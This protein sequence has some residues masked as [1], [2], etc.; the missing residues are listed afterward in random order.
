[1]KRYKHAKS[2]EKTGFYV[3]L[4]IC[5]VAVGLAVWSAYTGISDYLDASDDGY[6]ASLSD[7]TAAAVAQDMTGVTEPDT[8]PETEEPTE[9]PTEEATT[10]RSFTLYETST[11]PRS[12]E[13]AVLDELDSLSAVLRVSHSLIYP[14]K[15]QSV[16]KQ[17]S[18]DA[19]YSKTMRDYRAHTGCD[20]VAE[21]G[22][23]V[24]A[25]CGGTVSDIS[26]SELYGVIVTVDSGDF[27][28]YYCGLSP[29]L[30]VDKGDEVISGDTIGTVSEIPCESADESHIHIEI[31]SGGKLI[32][33]LTVIS[34][35]K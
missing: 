6:Y 1:M 2:G 24:Y 5:L 23:P 32:D 25:M 12:E 4:S 19:V 22:E 31:R 29:D 8:E 14:V 20:F 33:P 7:E 16:L 35:D 11:L 30:S 13:A 34:N 21:A 3:A 10:V 15:S 27:A 18:E 28:V 17:Y 26:V 9:P